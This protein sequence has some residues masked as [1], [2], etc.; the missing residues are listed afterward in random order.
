[1]ELTNEQV[2]EIYQNLS[3]LTDN[4]QNLPVKAS[5][6]IIRNL[7]T[8]KA[9]AQDIE[10]TR[11]GLIT[12][13]KGHFEDGIFYVDKED[14]PKADKLFH[15]LGEVKNQVTIYTFPI[16]LLDGYDVDLKTMNALF[17]MIEDGEG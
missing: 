2:V 4:T 10:Q 6:A 11:Q 13:L 3:N 8:L 9:I 12:S 17:F 16:S 5:Y 1:M 15:E 7:N 14:I